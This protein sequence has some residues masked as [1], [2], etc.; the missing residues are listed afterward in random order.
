MTD[1]MD[2]EDLRAKLV[3]EARSWVWTPFIHRSMVKGAGVDCAM[4]CYAVYSGLGL[5]DGPPPREYVPDWFQH[6]GEELLLEEIQRYG[7]LEVD[8]EPWPADIVIYKVAKVFAHAVI[9]TDWPRCVQA[10]P[11]AEYVAEIDFSI[12]TMWCWRERK[13]LSLW[14]RS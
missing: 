7:F 11:S 2:H 5:I 3:A 13:V 10:W 14:P 8:R 9:A 6:T 4:L 12:E 1:Q